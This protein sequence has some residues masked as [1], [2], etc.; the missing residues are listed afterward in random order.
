MNTTEML[1]AILVIIGAQILAACG[2]PGTPAPRTAEPFP[3]AEIHVPPTAMP[4][5]SA[6]PGV[7]AT[8]GENVGKLTKTIT[9]TLT[10]TPT[11]TPV[12]PAFTGRIIALACDNLFELTASADSAGGN[13]SLIASSVTDAAISPDL[14]YIVYATFS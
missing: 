2:A 14:R 4:E 7:L 13:Y 3:P 11:S 1:L 9:P 10:H 6:L 8:P 5:K 12:S